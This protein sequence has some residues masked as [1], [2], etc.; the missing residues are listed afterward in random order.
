VV[1]GIQRPRHG[2]HPGSRHA[3]G[4]CVG[5]VAVG[6]SEGEARGGL[7]GKHPGKEAVAPSKVMEVG[8]HRS[9]PTS[10]RWRGGT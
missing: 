3:P 8:A 7:A 1:H 4:A 9:G 5:G 2:V 10:G 6:D